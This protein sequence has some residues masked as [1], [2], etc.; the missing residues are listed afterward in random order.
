LLNF[1]TERGNIEFEKEISKIDGFINNFLSHNEKYEEDILE[2]SNKYDIRYGLKNLLIQ[3]PLK[4]KTKIV[5]TNTKMSF[6]LFEA[7][8]DENYLSVKENEKLKQ[9]KTN[10]STNLGKT[11]STNSNS[12]TSNT[13]QNTKK[14]AIPETP[15]ASSGLFGFLGNKIKDTGYFG[16]GGNS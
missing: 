2:T 9:S 7:R 3:N 8:I 14:A 5:K 11:T 6:K 4:D 16:F 13:N 12:S 10:E 15:V 1:F